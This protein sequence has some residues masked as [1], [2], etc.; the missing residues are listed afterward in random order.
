MVAVINGRQLITYTDLLWQVALQPDVPLENPRDRD[1]RA[2]LDRLIDQRLIAQEAEK[3]PTVEPTA[4][5][6]REELA[7]LMNFFPSQSVFYERLNRVGLGRDSE[8][9][10][11][12]VRSRVRIRKYLDFRFRSFT[13]VTPKE[14]EDYYR[15]VY[16]PR[17]RRERPGLIV[18]ELEKVYEE[19]Q[20]ELVEAK[21][22]ADMDD[23]LEEARATADLIILDERFDG[24]GR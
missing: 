13:V 20:S 8:Q 10:R 19:I 9:L 18:P 7:R 23:F 1:L 11:E 22:A 16:V 6:V 17:H 12:I 21:I 4:E 5:E 24:R 15:D 2:A 3:L 14:V